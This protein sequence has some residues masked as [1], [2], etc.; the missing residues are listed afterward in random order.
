MKTLKTLNRGL[1]LAMAAGLLAILAAAPAEAGYF[2]T[3]CQEE[4]EDSDLG[5]LFWVWE[6]CA[7]F[8]AELDDTDTKRF[9]YNLTGDNWWLQDTSL[10]PNAYDGGT[11]DNVDLFYINTHGGA[12][13]VSSTWA[14]YDDDM[15]A[16]SFLMRLGD[17][18]R[19]QSIFASYS[20]ETLKVSD[21]RAWT[22]LGSMVDGGLRYLA[23]SHDTLYD[24]PS[25]EEVGEEFAD[26]L[27]HGYTF[28][29]AWKSGNTDWATNQDLIV[30]ATGAGS[31][32]CN[33]RR[34]TMKWNNYHTYPRL[35]D[36]AATWMC[37][38]YWNNT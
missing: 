35:Q 1:G 20:C 23:G 22:R 28:R 11:L 16:Y 25:T 27:Q 21:G 12:G 29:N 30:I 6:R 9:Y 37:W 2:G 17:E 36:G 8:N 10:D 33:N 24:S 3:A 38:F 13:E 18:A 31:A 19:R 15:R 4:F 34:D 7:R 14:M 26:N 5:S 32:N